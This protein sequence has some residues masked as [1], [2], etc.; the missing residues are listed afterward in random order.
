MN[1]QNKWEKLFDEFL[2][3]IE[4]KLVK[5]KNGY[6]HLEDYTNANLGNIEAEEFD[7]ADWILD[8]L[9]NYVNDYIIDSIIEHAQELD[10]P[11][12]YNDTNLHILK[13]RNNFHEDNQWDFDILDMI[14]NHAQEIDLEN[15]TYE[16]EDN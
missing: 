14:C 9:S 8:R 7:N 2:D 15:C 13:Y 1:K 11:I 3:L 12:C 4:F 10:V 6:F 16:E 5:S